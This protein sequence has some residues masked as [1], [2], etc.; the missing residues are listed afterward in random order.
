MYVPRSVPARKLLRSNPIRILKEKIPGWWDPLGTGAVRQLW[1]RDGP[2]AR[3][4]TVKEE[5]LETY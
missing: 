1:L 3:T 4:K 5:G 2:E